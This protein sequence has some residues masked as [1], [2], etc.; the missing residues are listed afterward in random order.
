M[1]WAAISSSRSTRASRDALESGLICGAVVNGW[2]LMVSA[3]KAV[4]PQVNVW[5]LLPR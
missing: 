3:L 4:P 5:Q 2:V 1:R